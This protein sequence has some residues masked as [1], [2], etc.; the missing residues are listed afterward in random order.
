MNGT[1]KWSWVL[2][3]AL[4]VILL[5]G[6]GGD[7]TGGDAITSDEGQGSPTANSTELDCAVCHNPDGTLKT[8]AAA[9]AIPA[10]MVTPL[11]AGANPHGTH[12]TGKEYPCQTCHYDYFRAVTHMD[13]RQDGP[14]DGVQFVRF[15]PGNPDGEFTPGAGQESG[16]CASV[17]CHGG[18]SVTWATA[19]PLTCISC[20]GSGN[21][22]DPLVLDGNGLGGKH[23]HHVGKRGIDCEVCHQGFNNTTLHANG[24]LDAGAASSVLVIFGDLNPTAVWDAQQGTCAS[25]SCHGAATV[26][27]F[28]T[29]A[30]PPLACAGCHLTSGA[31]NPVTLDT[32]GGGGKHSRHVSDKGQDCE[33]CHTGY[34]GAVTHQ[35]GTLD[36]QTPGANLVAFASLN[37]GAAWD[38][39]AGTCASSSCHGTPPLGWYGSQTWT[40]PADCLVC[41]SPGSAIDPLQINGSGTLGKHQMH[42]ADRG[43]ACETCHGGYLT[44][45][46]HLNAQFDTLDQQASLVAFDANNT[47]AIWQNDAGGRTGSCADTYCHG[48]TDG[49]TTVANE[50]A[51]YGTETMAC[52]S[53]HA[54]G[55]FID[56][57]VINGASL[58]GQHQTHVGVKGFACETCHTGFRA[59][60]SHVNFQWDTGSPGVPIVAFDGNNP[61][62]AWND[63][64]ATCAD[65]YCHGASDGVTTTA[66]TP[67]WYT[68][69]ALG[70]TSCHSNNSFTYPINRDADAGVSTRHGK[71]LGE[72]IACE[73]CHSAYPLADSHVNFAFDGALL[74]TLVNFDPQVSTDPMNPDLIWMQDT[75]PGTGSCSGDC[76]YPGQQE[77]HGTENW[78]R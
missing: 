59:D 48:A 31:I 39:G 16:S 70:C 33:T 34:G 61:D 35:N 41:H 30:P 42:V 15:D 66:N 6:C 5:A 18:G 8:S 2:G 75:G 69:V 28:G 10:A 17:A 40:P 52:A 73:V 55:S 63:G 74:D 36:G 21:A 26:E 56:P 4:L 25:S 3:A 49:A 24:T 14:M 11:A 57:L 38:D 27:W 68:N 50:P 7:S 23:G 29:G 72:N 62:A 20:H 43:Y 12:V 51:W 47:N 58:N 78:Y 9:S 54:P 46:T 76:H 60:P 13:G 22:L 19:Q 65:T 71:H 44:A 67:P 64:P 45:P 37:A 77:N 32:A 1:A 53:C